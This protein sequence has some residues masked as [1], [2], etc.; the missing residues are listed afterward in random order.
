MIEL[1]D[2]EVRLRE[3]H[4]D[5]RFRLAVL[6]SNEHIANNLRDGFPHPYTPYDAEQFIQKYMQ[7][8]PPQVFA[9]EFQGEYA[10]N[11]GLHK[12]ADVY[13]KSAEIGYFLGE[14]YWNKGIMTRAVRLICE[15]GFREMDIV[16]I[17]TGVFEYNLASGRV[18]EKCGFLKEAVFT[19]AIFKNGEFWDEIRYAL[20]R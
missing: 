16:R 7:M 17:H 12:G 2:R 4:P 3:F 13:R 1:I 10:G 9:I 11:I 19:K 5:D 18:L 6:A 20:V 14:P 15:Y 8:D